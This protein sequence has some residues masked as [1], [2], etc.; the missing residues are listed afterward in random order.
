MSGWL[1]VGVVGDR[2][3]LCGIIDSRL[4]DLKEILARGDRKC[5]DRLANELHLNVRRACINRLLSPQM[6]SLL[7]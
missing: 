6:V 7:A 2:R 1:G 4:E 5:V 3:F